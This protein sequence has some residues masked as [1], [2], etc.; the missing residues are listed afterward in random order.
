M[1]TTGFNMLSF[2]GFLLKRTKNTIPISKTIESNVHVSIVLQQLDFLICRINAAPLFFLLNVFMDFFLP[3][4]ICIAV[5]NSAL[6]DFFSSHSLHLLE[7]VLL[8]KEA[9]IQSC[10]YILSMNDF[11]INCSVAYIHNCEICHF[12]IWNEK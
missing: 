2:Q 7:N 11:T 10:M 3:I 5:T 4:N 8:S 1:T 12:K 6:L 9:Y